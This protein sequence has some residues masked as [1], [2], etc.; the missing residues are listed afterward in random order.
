LVLIDGQ[1][2]PPHFETKDGRDVEADTAKLLERIRKTI[3]AERPHV[4]FRIEADQM[5]TTAVT[6]TTW[7]KLSSG[8][9]PPTAANW[10]L[11]P[12]T[13]HGRAG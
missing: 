1:C 9:P 12:S 6:A 8:R 4:L 11:S 10:T 13:M 7:E 5:V 3:A 2:C